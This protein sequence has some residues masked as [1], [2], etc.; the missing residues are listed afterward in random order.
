MKKLVVE[1]PTYVIFERKTKK[2]KKYNINLNNYRNWKFIVSN[3]I[4]QKYQEGIITSFKGKFKKA[5]ITYEYYHKGKRRIDMNNV[6]S[7][8]DKFFS[9]WLVHQGILE[10]DSIEYLVQTENIYKGEG[11]TRIIATVEE[12]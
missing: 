4:K 1:L 10:D 9:D 7:I 12:L 6:I 2:D 11:E 3:M 8:V 5:K